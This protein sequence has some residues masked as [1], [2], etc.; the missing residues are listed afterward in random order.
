M[1]SGKAGGHIKIYD[2]IYKEK[3]RHMANDIIS[4]TGSAAGVFH[5]R[6]ILTPP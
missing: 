6:T 2:F 5:S 4:G 3:G 1:P